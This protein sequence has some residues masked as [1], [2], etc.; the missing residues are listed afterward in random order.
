MRDSVELFIWFIFVVVFLAFIVNIGDMY[1]SAGYVASVN[2][3]ANTAISRQIEKTERARIRSETFTNFVEIAS[4][5]VV[6]IVVI[7]GL[8]FG[9]YK[10]LNNQAERNFQLAQQLMLMDTRRNEY[11]LPNAPPTIINNNFY[12]DNPTVVTPDIFNKLLTSN[13]FN[14][15]K[16]EEGYYTVVNVETNEMKLLEVKDG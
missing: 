10:F 1:N 3:R 15:D 9:G 16:T 4:I 14:V 5:V 12:F 13:K 6:S 11:R 2:A 8:L 7:G